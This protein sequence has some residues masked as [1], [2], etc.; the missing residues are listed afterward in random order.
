MSSPP[1][2]PTPVAQPERRAHLHLIP[3]GELPCRSEGAVY[4]QSDCGYEVGKVI[5]NYA[6][7][8]RTDGID[9]PRV[10]VHLADLYDPTGTK[11]ARFLLVNSTALWCIYCAEETRALPGMKV[12]YSPKGVRFMTL[13]VEDRDGTPASPAVVDDF[14]RTY[15][16]TT[17]VVSDPLEVTTLFFDKNAMPLNMIVDLRTM[18]IVKKIV[19]GSWSTVRSSLDLALSSG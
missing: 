5:P 6:F 3:H 13:V 1:R 17:I 2:P 18:R 11:G 4:P 14:I 8:G 12:D 9:S 7:E 19:G 15:S 10:T 16:L